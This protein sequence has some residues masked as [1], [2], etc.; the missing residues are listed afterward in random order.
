[1]VTPKLLIDFRCDT[2]ISCSNN[3]FGELIL[4][5]FVYCF[6]ETRLL[7]KPHNYPGTP[8]EAWVINWASFSTF[9]HKSPLRL[10]SEACVKSNSLRYRY[11]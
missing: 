8:S 10:K 4:R 1:M 6:V 9:S 7:V 11:D 2:A 3:Q 5:M